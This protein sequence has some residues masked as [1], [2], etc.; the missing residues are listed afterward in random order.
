MK[1]PVGGLSQPKQRRQRELKRRKT[2][3]RGQWWLVRQ[4][5]AAVGSGASASSRWL[6]AGQR[7]PNRGD[8]REEEQRKGSWTGL[9]GRE[10]EREQRELKG[11]E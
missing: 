5:T 3:V 1:R 11:F 2:T 6:A 7:R 8:G 4:V 10:K 9:A